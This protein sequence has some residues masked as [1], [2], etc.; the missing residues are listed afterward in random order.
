MFWLGPS[1]QEPP[2]RAPMMQPLPLNAGRVAWLTSLDEFMTRGLILAHF[3]EEFQGTGGGPARFTLDICGVSYMAEI[4]MLNIELECNDFNDPS[5][6][7]QTDKNKNAAI[8]CHEMHD[9]LF[10]PPQSCLLVFQWRSKQTSWMIAIRSSIAVDFELLLELDFCFTCSFC[11]M[12][13]A[14]DPQKE[15]H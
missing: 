9:F 4:A 11:F 15:F 12:S 5:T 14:R 3:C 8:S 10:S 13:P 6:R 7:P 2:L 1:L